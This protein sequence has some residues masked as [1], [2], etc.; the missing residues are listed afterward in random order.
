MTREDAIKQMRN[1]NKVSHI[2][3]CIDDCYLTM[4]GDEVLDESGLVVG[5]ISD[6]FMLGRGQEGWQEGWV[7]IE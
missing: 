7:I 2:L 4:R 3:L 5:N 1:G 6:A